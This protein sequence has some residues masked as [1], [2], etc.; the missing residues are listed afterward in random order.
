MKTGSN[1]RNSSKDYLIY[2]VASVLVEYK[3]RLSRYGFDT[4]GL[5]VRAL[6]CLLLL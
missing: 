2:D 4:S 5:I 3:D 1:L 6:G